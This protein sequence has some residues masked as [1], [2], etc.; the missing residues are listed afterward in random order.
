MADYDIE[1]VFSAFDVAMKW[2]HAPRVTKLF[3]DESDELTADE[4]S[5][6]EALAKE[7]AKKITD[8]NLRVVKAVQEANSDLTG[9]PHSVSALYFGKKRKPKP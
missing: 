2:I 8:E 6:V 1:K 4:F 9:N 7:E 5:K 3:L